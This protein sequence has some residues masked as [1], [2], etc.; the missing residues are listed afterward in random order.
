MKQKLIIMIFSA[1]LITGC[2][3]NTSKNEVWIPA[4][5]ETS[6]SYLQSRGE[7]LL[8]TWEK[9]QNDLELQSTDSTDY[10]M[11]LIKKNLQALLY[12]DVPITEVR[13]LIYDAGR[14]YALDRHPE[15]LGHLALAKQKLGVMQ[16]QGNHI[17]RLALQEPRI[18][19]EELLETLALAD[20]AK[21]S[22]N[23]AELSSVVTAQ[24]QDLGDNVNLMAIKGDLILTGVEFNQKQQAH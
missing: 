8:A 6:F 17:L 18:M 13:Q 1:L 21:G 2:Q 3:D 9:V 16:T 19:I 22:N 14:L 23:Q 24:F 7:R 4:L 11:S 20:Q 12:Y 15:T 10:E 5:H